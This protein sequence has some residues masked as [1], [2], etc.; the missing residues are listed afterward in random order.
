MTHQSRWKWQA[1]Q[2][3]E[4]PRGLALRK[5]DIWQ[6]AC[7]SRGEAEV[8]AETETEGSA[9]ELRSGFKETSAGWPKAAS[10]SAETRLAVILSHI[11]LVSHRPGRPLSTED[12]SCLTEDTAKVKY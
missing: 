5:A 7:C 11:P 1:V 4:L 6:A 3:E 8:E 10:L 12:A 9:S 2:E